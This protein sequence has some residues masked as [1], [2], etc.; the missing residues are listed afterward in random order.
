MPVVDSRPLERVS[1]RDLARACRLSEGKLDRILKSRSGEYRE[2]YLTA[3]SGKTRVLHVPSPR[4]KLA[5]KRTLR[6]L[7]GRVTPHQCSACVKDRGTHW[8][9]H[10]HAGHPSMLRL[11]IS[12]FFP[13]VREC[14]V[15]EGFVRLG[16]RERLT[17][18]LTRLVTLPDGL[19]QGAPTSVAVA[20][21]VLFP[22]DVRLAGMAERCGLTYSRYVDDITVSGGTRVGRLERLTRRIVADAGWELN[23][24]G[25]LVGPDQRHSLLGAVVN[26]KPNV[27][28]E[29]VREVR[30]YLRLVAK[31]LERP[32]EEDLRK[33]E[34]KVNWI[35]SVNPDR[36]R[37]LRP[38]LASA[39]ESCRRGRR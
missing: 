17:N 15:E 32:D 23:D 33:L 28:R 14:A 37:T 18:T 25:G 2:V 24:K 6:W 12:N 10:R 30:S 21:I 26:A 22:L 4:L 5:Q 8:A 35:L 31:G 19:P 9:Y 29:Y 3:A 1:V 7:V 11:D 16:A 38:L 34:S 36:E 13:S 39:I 20:D 27:A